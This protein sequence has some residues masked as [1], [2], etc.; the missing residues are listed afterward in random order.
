VLDED[1]PVRNRCE[2]TSDLL[3]G[4]GQSL[5]VQQATF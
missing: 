2:A 4:L 1:E 3:C 5:E